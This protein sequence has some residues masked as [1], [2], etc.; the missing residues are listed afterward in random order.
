MKTKFKSSGLQEE[1]EFGHNS[2]SPKAQ[3]GQ[4]WKQGNHHDLPSIGL[5]P[6]PDRLSQGNKKVREQ[7]TRSIAPFSVIEG[8]KPHFLKFHK[9]ALSFIW[10]LL[11]RLCVYLAF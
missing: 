6:S 1:T 8:I 4:S 7:D 3:F 2:Y 5:D 11:A 10:E 9:H